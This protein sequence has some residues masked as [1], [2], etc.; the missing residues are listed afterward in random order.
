MERTVKGMIL[1]IDSIGAP[2][3]FQ[4]NPDVLRGPTIAPQYA[5]LS[6]A[7][8][9]LPYLQYSGGGMSAM[10]FDLTFHTESD[11]GAAV[12][13]AWLSLVSLTSAFSFGFGAARPPR[14][15]FIL[16]SWPRYTWVITGLNPNFAI[17]T[18]GTFRN[19]LLPSQAIIGITLTRWIG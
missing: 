14:V 9:E 2:V 5:A 19:S 12:M 17:G 18:G 16:G 8:R 13:A 15:I 4:Y 11:G 1:P 6:V 3:L 10:P 7:G